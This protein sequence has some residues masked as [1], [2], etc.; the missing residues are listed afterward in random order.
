MGLAK[1]I[2]SVGA[3]LVE[4][5]KF[6]KELV[7]N[8]D[9]LAGGAEQLATGASDL[10]GGAGQVADGTQQLDET[11]TDA[12]E[13]ALPAGMRRADQFFGVRARF[14]LEAA[15]EAVGVIGE[16]AALGRNRALAVLDAALPFG[17]T[18]GRRHALLPELG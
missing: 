11:V 1:D 4:I 5:G 7:A 16:R 10:A 17:R 8:A 13:R 12:A 15:G 2:E 18:M 6:G 3:A 9:E 14:A